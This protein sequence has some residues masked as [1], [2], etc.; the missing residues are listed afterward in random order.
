M[1]LFLCGTR[2]PL[3]APDGTEKD[4]VFLLRIPFLH[5]LTFWST[6]VVF[7][8]SIEGGFFSPPNDL[9]LLT[10]VELALQM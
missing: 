6:S 2:S 5:I 3:Y 9:K 8:P 1:I 10:L 7:N 4:G